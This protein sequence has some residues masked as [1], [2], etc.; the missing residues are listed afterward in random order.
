MRDAVDLDTILCHE[1][2]C[3]INKT[4]AFL[5]AKICM[6]QLIAPR[7]IKTG[8]FKSNRIFIYTR[9]QKKCPVVQINVALKVFSQVLS[10]IYQIEQH[11]IRVY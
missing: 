4:I 5:N 2:T 10:I 7:Y 1:S 6:P 11:I 8:M 9:Q 3:F